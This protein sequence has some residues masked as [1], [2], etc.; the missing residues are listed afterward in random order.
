MYNVPTNFHSKTIMGKE[1]IQVVSIISEQPLYI[2]SDLCPG[3]DKTF[4]K[5]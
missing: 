5:K 3:A 4:L 2:L 1:N